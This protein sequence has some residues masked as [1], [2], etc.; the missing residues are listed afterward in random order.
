MG[1][2]WKKSGTG[3]NLMGKPLAAAASV[4]GVAYL[5]LSYRIPVHTME[6][7]V[8]PRMFPMLVAVGILLIS[9]LLWQEA[10]REVPVAGEPVDP[11]LRRRQRI[12]V[13]GVAAG[14]L[15]YALT[16]ETI[17]YLP[18]TFLLM[19][20]MLTAFNRG[21]HLLNLAVAAGV[22]I[23]LYYGL[24]KGLGVSLPVGFL[25]FLR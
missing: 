20:G 25:T 11:E 1:A 3:R 10:A 9:V 16:L 7:P 17:G 6:D 5:A 19:I 8:G 24:R 15:V 21:R 22:A 12:G 4:L 18:G 23:V 2:A 13:I 14:T